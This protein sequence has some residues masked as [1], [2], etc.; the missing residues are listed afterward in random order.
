MSNSRTLE[1][2]L[3]KE[4]LAII[5]HD[6][7]S[8]STFSWTST[9]SN[10]S[11]PFSLPH[12][13]CFCVPLSLSLCF[14]LTLA[15]H[16]CVCLYVWHTCTHSLNYIISERV[17]LMQTHT[18]GLESLY[19]SSHLSPSH[20]LSLFLFSLSLSLS[21]GVSLCTSYS[22]I[23]PPSRSHSYFCNNLRRRT[24]FSSCNWLYTK[25][26]WTHK[27]DTSNSFSF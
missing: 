20:S 27:Q 4:I 19:L 15:V 9:H 3:L 21:I 25:C 26:L 7:F 12:L 13:R 22:Q 23:L 10:I 17:S 8:C 6:L 2:H 1:V 16:H 24:I 18:Q 14:S 5:I 11:Q